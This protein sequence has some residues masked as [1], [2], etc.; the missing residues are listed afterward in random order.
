MIMGR[1]SHQPGCNTIPGDSVDSGS[2]YRKGKARWLS[3]ACSQEERQCEE[4]LE[5]ELWLRNRK[6]LVE[7]S[8]Q[9]DLHCS[10]HFVTLIS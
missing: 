4:P 2:Y 3:G 8:K 5:R 1:D 6:A 7:V 9:S 10:K